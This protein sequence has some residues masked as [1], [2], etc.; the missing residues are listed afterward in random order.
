[1]RQR[2]KSVATGKELGHVRQTSQVF[3]TEQFI[4]MTPARGQLATPDHWVTFRCFS[5]KG[6][7]FLKSIVSRFCLD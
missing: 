2:K 4:V 1:M 3:I 7:L 5:A 6:H